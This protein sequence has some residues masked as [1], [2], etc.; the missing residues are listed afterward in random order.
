LSDTSFTVGLQVFET[1]STR[2]IFTIVGSC[3]VV[4]LLVYYLTK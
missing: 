4:F 3:V 2:T 1:K